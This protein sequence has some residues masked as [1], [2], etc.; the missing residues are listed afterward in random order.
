MNDVASSALY[1]ESED[2][3][4]ILDTTPYQLRDLGKLLQLSELITHPPDGWLEMSMPRL[5]SIITLKREREE[6]NLLTRFQRRFREALPGLAP[7]TFPVA[8]IA[9]LQLLLAPAPNPPPAHGWLDVAQ[10]LSRC[11]LLENCE[12][13]QGQ[14]LPFTLTCFSDRPGNPASPRWGPNLTPTQ[15]P[16]SGR[17]AGE[18]RAAH[19]LPGRP[20]PAPCPLRPAR[21]VLGRPGAPP[22]GSALWPPAGLAAAPTARRPRR[23][24][25]PPTCV[26]RSEAQPVAA[27]ALATGGCL[28]SEAAGGRNPSPA[29]TTHIC[30]IR[31][32]P[33]LSDSGLEMRVG[34]PSEASSCRWSARGPQ[35]GPERR[36][37]GPAHVVRVQLFFLFSETGLS[38]FLPRVGYLQGC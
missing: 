36:R 4:P 33:L 27:P 19:P 32:P 17:A 2:P 12:L 20:Q 1:L 9:S 8:C 7:G 22:P 34:L 26:E 10:L 24:T 11:E 25:R 14:S 16:P 28:T 31:S 23:L 5:C 30:I 37:S 21:P 38:T 3:V 13:F 29:A 15:P 18:E 35:D 6:E